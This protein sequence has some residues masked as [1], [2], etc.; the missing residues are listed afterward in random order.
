MEISGSV[1]IAV[2]GLAVSVITFFIGRLSAA[3]SSGQEYGV[4]L[5]E[6]GYIKSGV[7]ELK[8]KTEQSDRRYIELAERVTALEE[9]VKIYHQGGN[10]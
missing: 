1:L 10:L 7:D 5:T 2:M 8:K 9:T 6:I 4:M 3:R